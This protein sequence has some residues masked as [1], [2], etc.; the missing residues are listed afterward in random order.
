MGS[1]IFVYF[2]FDIV[3]G[4]EVGDIGNV[5]FR[6]DATQFMGQS[7]G[8]GENRLTLEDGFVAI[9]GEG[10]SVSYTPGNQGNQGNQTIGGT[11]E[12]QPDATQPNVTQPEENQPN[13]TQPESEGNDESLTQQNP[14]PEYQ[15]NTTQPQNQAPE[16]GQPKQDGEADNSYTPQSSTPQQDQ[17][18]DDAY[19]P[20][21][22]DDSEA[23]EAKEDAEVKEDA[24]AKEAK[25][26]TETL[27][28]KEASEATRASEA[29]AT[30]AA[31][32]THDGIAYDR[33]AYIMG[34]PDGSVMPDIA[35]TRAEVALIFFRLLDDANKFA[36]VPTD[37]FSDVD[38][39]SGYSQAVHYLTYVGIL[40]GYPDGTFRPDAP[41]TRAEFAAIVVRFF[42]AS[43]Q[44]VA[45]NNFMDVA[46]DHWAI[47]CI[48]VAFNQGW[49]QGYPNGTFNL[50]NNI[51]R[52]EVVTL[53][54]R[55]LDR[56]PNPVYIRGSLAGTIV[57]TDISSTHWAFYDIMEASMGGLGR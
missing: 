23:V 10:F 6:H 47:Y 7:T 8:L 54:N 14:A 27:E 51:T 53:L 44:D 12:G 13:L 43:N 31:S 29:L 5:F 34:F 39:V 25:D 11:P 52:A 49:V 26:A 37:K 55:A 36:D 15:P 45:T 35:I 38:N 3:P 57:Y 32:E 41:I 42:G 4:V 22:S 2:R 28:A 18:A 56:T 16:G 46:C 1:S 20:N 9:Y 30:T 50:D 33:I 40:V 48:N 21:T 17:D 19:T 24:E